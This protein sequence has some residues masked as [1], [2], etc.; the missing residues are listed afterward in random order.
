MVRIKLGISTGFTVKRWAA[1]EEWVHIVKNKLGLKI[2]QF[3]FDQFDP[4]GNRDCVRAYCRRLTNACQRNGVAIHSTFT[5]LAVY[6]HNL[7]YHPLLEGRL[8]G[9]D[10]F[11]NAFAMTSYLGATATGGPFGGMDVATFKEQSKRKFMESWAEEALV[12]LLQDAEGHGIKYFYWEPTPVRREG[13]VTIEGTKELLEKINGLTGDNGARFALCLDT[14]HAT[15]P[16]ASVDDRNPYLWLEKLGKYS[17]VVHLQQSDGQLDRHWPFTEQYNSQGIIQAD[18]VL[19]ALNNSG[20]GEVTLF[21]EVCHP[22]EEN[23]DRVLDDIS[24]SVEYWQEA[25][26]RNNML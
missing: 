25:L 1:P 12:R 17:P 2:V 10:W 26:I 16:H 5:G 19:E 24:R 20:V 13:P 3:S 23:D 18:K 4:R 15:S 9:L 14:G 22:F 11:D 6:T 21:V 7:L 8:D